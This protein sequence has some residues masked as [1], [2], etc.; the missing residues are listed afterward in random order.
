[1]V[2]QHGITGAIL[3]GGRGRR[4]G[5]VDKGL[6]P[7]LGRPLI[8]HAIER[9]R[10][11]V[12]NI[13]VSAN[14]HHDRYAQLGLPVVSDRDGGFSG[15][16]AGIA[17]ILE[18]VTADYVLVVPCDMPFLP[19]DLARTLLAGLTAHGS[20]AA[21]AHGASRLQ[22]LCV[23]LKRDVEWGLMRYR[24]SGG[25]KVRDW[26]QGL[27]HCVVDF[28]ETPEAF[29]NINTPDNLHAAALI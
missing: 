29:C 16:L 7:F 27:R 18:E 24:R 10:P 11:Q 26:L 9:L 14:R 22:P 15:P 4:M 5:A 2:D 12:E 6:L 20:E 17:R 23:L 8:S 28:P 19:L 13:V 3:A 1:M 21:V 25:A